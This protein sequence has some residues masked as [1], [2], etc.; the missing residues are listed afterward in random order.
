MEGGEVMEESI[1]P[2]TIAKEVGKDYDDSDRSCLISHT[3]AALQELFS[4]VNPI[5]M[6]W[7]FVMLRKSRMM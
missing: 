4:K 3:L 5:Y 2:A 6:L 1:Y 7:L